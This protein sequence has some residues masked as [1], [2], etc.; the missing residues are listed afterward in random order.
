MPITPPNSGPRS[1]QIQNLK[2][3]ETVPAAGSL[4]G[5]NAAG[6]TDWL[7]VKVQDLVIPSTTGGRLT[8]DPSEP[9]IGNGSSNGA[10]WF[11]P[12]IHDLI[13][14]YDG[15]RW[16]YHKIFGTGGGGALGVVHSG[17]NPITV[18]AGNMA[19]A[20]IADVYVYDDGGMLSIELHKWATHGV[21]TSTRAVSFGIVRQNGVWVSENDSTRR[22]VG[23][24]KN[25][26]DIFPTSAGIY[27]RDRS[28]GVWNVQNQVLVRQGKSTSDGAGDGTMTF[29]SFQHWS[30]PN[31]PTG[32]TTNDYPVEILVGLPTSVR[33]A[34]HMRTNSFVISLPISQSIPDMVTHAGSSVELNN[35][36][37]NAVGTPSTP[38]YGSSI[39][40]AGTSV[41]TLQHYRA[42]R[43]DVVPIGVNQFQPIWVGETWVEPFDPIG[44]QET[45]NSL[46]FFY[47]IEYLR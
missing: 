15:A 11:V 19:N 39:S 2:N 24:M 7:D 26:T 29:S 8:S 45:Q 21:G 33:C 38:N 13:A 22:Y 46:L 42:S 23:T 44:T 37:A 36:T 18:N 17:F 32:S 4:L 43:S 6:K 12:Y 40:F 1:K 28:M 25:G 41:N 35:N 47:E 31:D 9:I 27:M 30:H 16:N 10:V 14:L 3:D 5:V 34:F 20:E